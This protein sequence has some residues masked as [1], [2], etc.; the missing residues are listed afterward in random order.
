MPVQTIFMWYK[1]KMIHNVLLDIMLLQWALPTKK[2][3][4]ENEKN[5]NTTI[6][7]KKFNWKRRNEVKDSWKRERNNYDRSECRVS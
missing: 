4:K 1:Q 7:A 3:Q 2:G 6:P 5:S